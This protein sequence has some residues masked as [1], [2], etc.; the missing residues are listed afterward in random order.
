MSKRQE[1]EQK[2]QGETSSGKVWKMALPSLD[3]GAE[4]VVY[5]CCSR[6]AG[7]RRGSGGADCR[8]GCGGRHSR[9]PGWRDPSKGAE[10]KEPEKVETVKRRGLDGNEK[11]REEVKVHV[12]RNGPAWSTEKKYMRR[13]K[14]KCDIFFGIEH[15]LRKEEV[16]E[17]CQRRMEVCSECSENY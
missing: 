14:G 10:G 5:R 1:E 4:L 16:E 15:R 13:Y 8:V 9:G 7:A 2:S 11:G 12:A 6:E 3:F 17:Q